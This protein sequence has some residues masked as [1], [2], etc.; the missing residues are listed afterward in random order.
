MFYLLVLFNLSYLLVLFIKPPKHFEYVEE[1]VHVGKALV[2]LVI[3]FMLN[4]A[5]NCLIY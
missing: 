5:E 4:S 2:Y 3:L 1:N